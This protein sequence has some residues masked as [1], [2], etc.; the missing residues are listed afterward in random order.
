MKNKFSDLC[1]VYNL[2][3]L[4]DGTTCFKNDTPIDVLL[5]TE[6]KQFKQP[7][8]STCS[9]RDFHNF[10]CVATKPHK[11]HIGQKTIYYH[12]NKTVDDGIFLN[13]VQNI[14]LSV[15]NSFEDEDDLLL[16]LSKLFS[17]FFDKNPPLKRKLLKSFPC[18]I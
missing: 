4:V 9:L 6:T 2:S 7:L 14:L 16:S 3:N 8:N 11:L 18:L 1:V 10:T 13:D 12:S 15:R 17:V 5:S